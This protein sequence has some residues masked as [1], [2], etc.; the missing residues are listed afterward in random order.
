MEAR[1]RGLGVLSALLLA[2]GGT[3]QAVED[4]D[5]FDEDAQFVYGENIGWVNAEPGGHGGAGLRIEGVDVTGYLWSE[6]V[7]W[8]NL[9]CL[10]QGT[11]NSVDYGTLLHEDGRIE[12]LAWAEN[13]GWINLSPA[14][15]GGVELVLETGELYGMAWGENVGWISLSSSAGLFGVVLDLG[16]C[17]VG[18]DADADG[19]E[20]AGDNCVLA[21]NPDQVDT[22]ADGYGNLC[23][24][25]LNNDGV[26]GVPDMNRFR[27][28]FGTG[29]GDPGYDPEADFQADGV[30]GI[31][32]LNVIRGSLGGTPGPS[33][34]ECAG[35]AGGCP[36]VCAP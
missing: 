10:N 7:G 12:G 28:A 2:L 3:A 9:S 22:D 13:V 5:P 11:C 23:D 34:L 21:F 31:P 24:A 17:G 19:I 25:D 29:S 26:I 30:I 32:D 1:M 20:D 8:I 4:V 27:L 6:N 18:P 36:A 33:G 16:S 35:A 14:I 15:G